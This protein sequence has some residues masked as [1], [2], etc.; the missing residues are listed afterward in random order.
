MRLVSHIEGRARFKFDNLLEK[1]EFIGHMSRIE[2][3]K[4]L[5]Y[6]EH[7]DSVLIHYKPKS[8]MAF[9]ISQMAV[10]TQENTPKLDRNDLYFYT[11]PLIKHPVAKAAWSALVLGV[12]K[13]ILMFAICSMGVHRYLDA[14]IK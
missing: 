2:G 4:S 8:T 11:V 6:K 3:A 14:K 13:G 5:D 9:V 12:P 1:R 7:T 10:G